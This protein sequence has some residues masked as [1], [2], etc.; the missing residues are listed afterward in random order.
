VNSALKD[1]RDCHQ[2]GR[3]E[4]FAGK[5]FMMKNYQDQREKQMFVLED[6]S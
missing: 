5:K 1:C 6:E 4:I 2:S 3:S